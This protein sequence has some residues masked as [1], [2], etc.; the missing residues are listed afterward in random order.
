MLEDW[1]NLDVHLVMNVTDVDD[2]IIARARR[3]V[4]LETYLKNGICGPVGD[5]D[6]GASSSS[7]SPPQV[8]KDAS[9]AL[10]LALERQE[11][12]LKR[13]QEAAEAEGRGKEGGAGERNKA[14][15]DGGS[16]PEAETPTTLPSPSLDRRLAKELAESVSVEELKAEQLRQA[17]LKLASA[18]EGDLPAILAAAGD[19]LAEHLDR[20]RGLGAAVTDPAVFREHA[21]RYEAEFLRDME[22]LRVRPP[23]V[24]TRVSEYM[25]GEEN[26]SKVSDLFFPLQERTR[27]T[28]TCFFI[29]LFPSS[30]FFSPFFPP[31]FLSLVP[32]TKKNETNRDRRL[33]L[34]DRR[35][36]LRLRGPEQRRKLELQFKRRFSRCLL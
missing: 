35:L 5:K 33:C 31:L 32:R 29:F 24:L 17:S 14:S 10:S 36:R 7:P 27:K 34:P 2:K 22:A 23:S 26:E 4:V 8:K 15:G 20:E 18:S 25:E 21:A 6:N 3:G 19:V 12:R 11:L 30:L 28:K 9:V 1:F 13:A 16:K